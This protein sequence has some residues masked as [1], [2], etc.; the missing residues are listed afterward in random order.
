MYVP[1]GNAQK[2]N[3]DRKK[4]LHSGLE[5]AVKNLTEMSNPLDSWKTN[6]LKT[7]TV[8]FSIKKAKNNNIILI[9]KSQRLQYYFS[10]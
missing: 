10:Y 2:E 4:Y 9:G 5:T 7:K 3:R 8:D 1:Q 6:L